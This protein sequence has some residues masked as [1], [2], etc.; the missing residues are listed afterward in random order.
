MEKIRKFRV[1]AP[2]TYVS[3]DFSSREAQVFRLEAGDGGRPQIASE[4]RGAPEQE[5]LRRQ[6]EDFRRAVV[7][8]STPR[9]PGADGRRA[10]AL[11][12]EILSRMEEG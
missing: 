12:H 10:L 5:P 1:F 6:I 7:E 4:K 8:R 2:R 3:V 9:V 11:A